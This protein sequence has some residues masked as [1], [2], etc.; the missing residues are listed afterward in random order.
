MPCHQKNIHFISPRLSAAA[1]AAYPYY[2]AARFSGN[3]NPAICHEF[4]IC[5]RGANMLLF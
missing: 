4:R 2:I 5:R 1:P 3:S